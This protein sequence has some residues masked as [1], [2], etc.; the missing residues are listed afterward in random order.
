MCG[1]KMPVGTGAGSKRYAIFEKTSITT[2]AWHEWDFKRNVLQGKTISR[3]PA[4]VRRRDLFMVLL[5]IA[6]LVFL[7]LNLS[8]QPTKLHFDHLGGFI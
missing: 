2:K 7:K 3:A 1:I 6:K 5:K 4:V 8:L